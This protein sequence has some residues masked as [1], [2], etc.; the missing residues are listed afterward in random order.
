MKAD[1]ETK[2]DQNQTELTG[3][4]IEKEF[5]TGSK[6]EHRGIYLQTDE[7]DY[8]LRRVGGNPFSDPEL[9]K[10]VGEKVRATGM[11]SQVLFL[12]NSIKKCT[13]LTLQILFLAVAA[14][15]YL[16]KQTT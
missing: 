10:L 9:K 1:K 8:Q 15:P 12:A 2:Q 5:G 13:W 16:V 6:S 11:L 4:V 14:R 7:G 3:T